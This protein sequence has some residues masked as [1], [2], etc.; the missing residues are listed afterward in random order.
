[1]SSC[2]YVWQIGQALVPLWAAGTCI[3][4]DT[5]R[6]AGQRRS[7][8]LDSSI[9]VD[10][11]GIVHSDGLEELVAEHVDRHDALFF[12]D[13]RHEHTRGSERVD[14]LGEKQGLKANTDRLHPHQ[15]H[16]AHG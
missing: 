9:H 5:C 10:R 15:S 1:V 2:Q 14:R 12:P 3:A 8:D 13:V 16:A 6:I 11:D 7:A 4:A